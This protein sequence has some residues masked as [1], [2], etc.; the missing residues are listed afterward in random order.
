MNIQTR[1][2]VEFFGLYDKLNNHLEDLF[3]MFNKNA[4]QDGVEYFNKLRSA[5]DVSGL[6][7]RLGSNV[8]SVLSQDELAQIVQLYNDNP[9]LM[10]LLNSYDQLQKMDATAASDMVTEAA[11]RIPY[12]MSSVGEC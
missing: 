2:Y 6:V 12:V 11:V 5:I 1:R 9:V 7:S 4:D 10:K 3:D 8:E